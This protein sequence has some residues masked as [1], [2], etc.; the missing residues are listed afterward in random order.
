[1]STPEPEF[2]LAQHLPAI[3]VEC[4]AGA[5]L[6]FT[7]PIL[8]AGG[9]PT[10][11]ASILAARAQVRSRVEDAEI[12]HSWTTDTP[13]GMTVGGGA[14][15]AVTLTASGLETAIWGVQWSRL[16][17]VWDLEVVDTDG[18]PHRLCR[19]SPFI[20]YPEVTREL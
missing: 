2:V 12:L 9:T 7:V 1:M 16:T 11:A 19:V 17:A 15:G 18:V 10:N 3:Q 20:V 5:P 14:D 8:G 13:A 4:Y 6:A